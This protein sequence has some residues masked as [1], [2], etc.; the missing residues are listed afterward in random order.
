MFSL[1]PHSRGIATNVIF[2]FPSAG[3]ATGGALGP[4]TC[5]SPDRDATRYRSVSRQ[6]IFFRTRPS[7]S[8]RRPHCSPVR[9]RGPQG[10]DMEGFGASPFAVAAKMFCAPSDFGAKNE[11]FTACLARSAASPDCPAVLRLTF[12][13][14]TSS[15]R[16]I[17]HHIPSSLCVPLF[18]SPVELALPPAT[19]RSA[20]RRARWFRKSTENVLFALPALNT[21]NAKLKNFRN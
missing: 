12:S 4:C 11:H 6:A 1:S 18:L 13:S 14:P 16:L 20:S 8:V 21:S 7:S 3:S 17:D 5:C 19:T 15:P 2:S 9:P 10:Q